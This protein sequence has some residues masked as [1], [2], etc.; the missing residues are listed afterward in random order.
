MRRPGTA[1]NREV[2]TD[3]SVKQQMAELMSEGEAPTER[4][5]VGDVA[6]VDQDSRPV[7]LPV[8]GNTPDGP[9]GQ[10]AIDNLDALFLDNAFDVY[11][12]A[13]HE[14]GIEVIVKALGQFVSLVP[15]GS[16]QLPSSG[17][18]RRASS[19]ADR[20]PRGARRSSIRRASSSDIS[21]PDAWRDRTEHQGCMA[22]PRNDQ[23]RLQR[24][25][26]RT[27]GTVSV[28]GEITCHPPPSGTNASLVRAQP[29]KPHQD[30]V[31]DAP[32]HPSR[33]ESVGA[34]S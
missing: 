33:P 3:I 17:T 21:F 25:Q 27:A 23:R 15:G 8:K 1:G 2:R 10:L 7:A 26:N 5:R 34:V 14:L 22:R 19:I 12:L 16:W 30:A 13:L 31:R 20:P 18:E 11:G 9:I 4:M 6:R 29:R 24:F 32:P 28:S